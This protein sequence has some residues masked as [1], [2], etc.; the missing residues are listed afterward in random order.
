MPGLERLGGAALALD[1]L[2]QAPGHFAQR[3]GQRFDGAGAR[4]GIGDAMDIGLLD[5]N[6]LRVAGDAAGERIGQPKR[7][8]ERQHRHGIGAADRSAERGDGAAHDVPVRIALGH[9]APGGLGG[10]EGGQGL[11]PARL[12]DARP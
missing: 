7:R 8:A 2:K 9:H 10:D 5:Q 11:E 12:L 4:G 3:I 1:L 6:G